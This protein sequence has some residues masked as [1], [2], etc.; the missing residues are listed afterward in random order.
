MWGKVVNESYFPLKTNLTTAFTGHYF[1]RLKIL[2]EKI[3]DEIDGG[4]RHKL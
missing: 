3:R 2:E 4:R 1:L